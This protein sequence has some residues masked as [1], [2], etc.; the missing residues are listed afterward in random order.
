MPRTVN[1]HRLAEERSLAY[2]Q[3][4]AEKL[5]AEPQLLDRAR[6]RVQSWLASG[7][8]HPHYASAWKEILARSIAEVQ[9]FLAQDSE[10][11]RALRQVTPFAG[12]LDPRTRWRIWRQVREALDKAR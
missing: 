3:A 4:V 11:A 1:S 10:N 8:V 5:A 12:A 2:H 7:E 9:A 6:A